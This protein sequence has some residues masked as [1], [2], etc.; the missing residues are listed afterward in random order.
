MITPQNCRRQSQKPGTQVRGPSSVWFRLSART[1]MPPG[2][3][4]QTD[5]S[6]AEVSGARGREPRRATQGLHG[7]RRASK[8]SLGPGCCSFHNLCLL[9]LSLSLSH[10]HTHTQSDKLS[11]CLRGSG[12][13]G[14]KGI[15][16]RDL[17]TCESCGASQPR[18][19]SL[20]GQSPPASLSAL[21]KNSARGSIFTPFYRG[22]D[23]GSKK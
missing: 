22:G 4:D 16:S 23:R 1:Q 10:T 19:E 21:G 17:D 5:C 2:R 11:Q 18:S 6:A 7:G 12:D 13:K 15:S 8:Q 9:S 14:E 3:G 20:H